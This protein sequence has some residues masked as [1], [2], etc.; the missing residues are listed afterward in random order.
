MASCPVVGNVLG[1]TWSD[2]R[3]VMIGAPV[4]SLGISAE[5]TLWCAVKMAWN[6]VSAVGGSHVPAVCA[7]AV[8]FSSLKYGLMTLS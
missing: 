5:L 6:S 3:Y 2:C 4:S 8:H 7:T 1:F